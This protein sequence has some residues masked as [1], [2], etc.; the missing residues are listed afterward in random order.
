MLLRIAETIAARGKTVS[1]FALDYSLAP[2][3]VFPR[4]LNQM[5]AG[6][7]YLIEERGVSCDNI[8]LVGDS[9]GGS[10]I[11]SFL[12]HRHIPL[13]SV[14]LPK[15]QKVSEEYNGTT[16]GPSGKGV[17]LINP[18]VSLSE[19]RGYAENLEGDILAPEALELWAK[20][21][22]GST[23]QDTKTKYLEFS[24][25]NPQRRF[26]DVLPSP[27]WVSAG[28]DE[29]FRKN[30]EKFVE[31]VRGDSVEVKFTL[32]DGQTHD[33]QQSEALENQKAFL[34]QEFL[35]SD[36]GLLAGA[37]EIGEAIASS[38]D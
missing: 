24:I 27:V 30:I 1:I 12:T 19:K 28:G 13:S 20:L 11:L 3:A 16:L 34:A 37:T 6:Y 36:G 25:S 23:S 2:E 29:I 26:E 35:T 15:G 7:N 31:L 10:L 9:A 33:W 32:A 4:Q 5:T 17:Y 22:L 18:W 38:L 21:V 8:A 14:T